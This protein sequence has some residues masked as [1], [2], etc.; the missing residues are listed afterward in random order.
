M[1]T[2]LNNVGEVLLS[3]GGEGIVHVL[4]ESHLHEE[5]R[6]EPFGMA[7]I[8]LLQQLQGLPFVVVLDG[9][10]LDHRQD[11]DAETGLQDYWRFFFLPGHICMAIGVDQHIIP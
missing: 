6:F 5:A 7:E 8:L 4:L 10:L 1:R 11:P 3:D 2:W 9:D